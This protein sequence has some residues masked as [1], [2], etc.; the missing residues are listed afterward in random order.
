MSSA[1][2]QDTA[3][4]NLADQ[5]AARP[6]LADAAVASAQYPLGYHGNKD[7][8]E[9]W[10]TEMEHDWALLGGRSTEEQ[11]R[12]HGAIYAFRPGA[13][14]SVVRT[15]RA[16]AAAIL[17]ELLAYLRA[18]PQLRDYPANATPAVRVARLERCT[19]DQGFDDTGRYCL[20]EFWIK[21]EARLSGT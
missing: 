11:Y 5:L 12:I 3:I 9:L 1:T 4:T 10:Q 13:S 7:V 19:I 2:T 14:E 18:D 21:C 17:D 6:G 16:G 15:A 20:I 8:I